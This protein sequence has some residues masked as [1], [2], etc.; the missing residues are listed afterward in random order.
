MEE[1]G[2]AL[3]PYVSEAEISS[4]RS[5]FSRSADDSNKDG[6]EDLSLDNTAKVEESSS[7]D[8]QISEGVEKVGE[9]AVEDGLQDDAKLA[10]VLQREEFGGEAGLSFSSSGE[11]EEHA[12]E[13]AEKSKLTKEEAEHLAYEL[14]KKIRK[15]RLEREKKE[16]IERERNRIASSKLMQ[17][18]VSKLEEQ[19]RHR[20]IKQM[21]KEKEEHEK[22]RQRQLELIRNDWRERFGAEYPGAESG[23]A[24]SGAEKDGEKKKKPV[25]SKR[26][27]VAACC[28]KVYSLNK[29]VKDDASLKKCLTTLK[30]YIGNAYNN[31]NEGKFMRI[32]KENETFKTKV[33]SFEGTI[34]LLNAVGFLENEDGDFLEITPPP[35]GFILSC[36]LKYIEVLLSRF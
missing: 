24:S 2:S 18:Q 28:N 17:E 10:E 1:G 4:S 34:A 23:D 21:Q 3:P 6:A 5:I 20:A 25:K 11:K 31:P 36:A 26:E 13:S 29:D 9:D 27:A 15:E 16:A 33:A 7:R 12:G 14:Q 22:E 30:L 32:K 19:T 35:D 8:P